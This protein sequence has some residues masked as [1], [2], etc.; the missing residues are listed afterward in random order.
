MK[1]AVVG[2]VALQTVV[3]VE[4]VQTAGTVVVS[5]SQ[6]GQRVVAGSGVGQT[7][8]AE[9]EVEQTVE[10]VVSPEAVLTLA[11]QL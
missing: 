11:V 6:L 7:V 9:P 10:A 3:A 5:G 4:A 8:L 2:T 1:K